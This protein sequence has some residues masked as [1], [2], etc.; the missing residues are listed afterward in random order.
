VALILFVI[1][2]LDV[3]LSSIGSRLSP[4]ERLFIAWVGP[5]GI[6]AASVTALF[7]VRLEAI[8][9]EGADDLVPLV[10]MVIVATVLLASLTAKPLGVR[11]GVA[12]PDPQGVLLLGAHPVGRQIGLALDKLGVSVLL[13][14]TNLSNVTEAR[15]DGLQ[16][17][18][19]SLLA[20]RSDDRLRLAGIGRLVALTSNDEA[21][22]LTAVKYAREFGKANV[23]QL[24][25]RAQDHHGKRL[26]G[27]HRGRW[28][29]STELSFET[30]ETLHRA[31]ATVQTV[32]LSEEFSL[33]DYQAES[34]GTVV[35]LFLVTGKAVRVLSEDTEPERE[36]TGTV[37]ALASA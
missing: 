24:A 23:F 18:F 19:G 36:T 14:D 6:V 2:P 4:R 35:P 33:A 8:G 17:Y 5:R 20:D 9:L 25:P 3:F 32:E 7:A 13:A 15:D 21:N 31:G 34:G 37:V 1:R 12:D 29:S 16:T 28:L 30:I 10:F 27:E 22:A 26:G 11:L